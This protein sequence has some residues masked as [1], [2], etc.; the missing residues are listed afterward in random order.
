M[1]ISQLL[2]RN[3]KLAI[4][5]EGF[6]GSKILSHLQILFTY[7]SWAKYITIPSPVSAH[8]RASC[9]LYLNFLI[10]SENVIFC[11]TSLANDRAQTFY[12]FTLQL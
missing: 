8:D 3:F 9:F 6:N 5:Y 11:K 10:V 12:S 4:V 1:W 2:C 7:R